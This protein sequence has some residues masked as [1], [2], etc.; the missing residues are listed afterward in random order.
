MINVFGVGLDSH[1][2][3]FYYFLPLGSPTKV[4]FNSNSITCSVIIFFK[5][6][7]FF[8][9]FKSLIISLVVSTMFVTYLL[10][11]Y[12]I[13]LNIFMYFWHLIIF[14]LVYLDCIFL[15]IIDFLVIV[16][17][18]FYCIVFTCVLCYRHSIP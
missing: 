9:I 14:V 17:T 1:S 12:C 16:M 6:M 11:H 15:E 5:F 2:F 4:A 13:S 8:Y 7:I 18:D 3:L 10:K